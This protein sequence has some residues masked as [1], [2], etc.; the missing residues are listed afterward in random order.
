MVRLS[1]RGISSFPPQIFALTEQKNLTSD[2]KWWEC[3]PLSSIDVSHN[4]LTAIPG[5]IGELADLKVLNLAYNKLTSLPVEISRL[6]LLK[7]IKSAHN[8]ISKLDAAMFAGPMDLAELELAHNQ[9]VSIPA[10]LSRMR[11]LEVLDLSHNRIESLPESL[12]ELAQL[13]TL[14]L[15]SNRLSGLPSSLDR[16]S[17]LSTLEAPCNAIFRTPNLAR[18]RIVFLDMHQNRLAELPA[19]PPTVQQVHLAYNQIASLSG[20]ERASGLSTL[21]VSNNKLRDIPSALVQC[22]QLKLLDVS[23]NDLPTVPGELGRLEALNTLKLDGNPLRAFKRSLISA[24]ISAVKKWLRLRAGDDADR[25]QFVK[26]QKRDDARVLRREANA[27]RSLSLRGRGLAELPKGVL[28]DVELLRSLDLS[29]NRLTRV[30]AE[31]ERHATSLAEL[32]LDENKLEMFPPP[33]SRLRALVS[34]RVRRN[35]LVTFPAMPGFEGL[36]TLDLRANRLPGFPGGVL[37]LAALRTLF[38]G[39]N[40]IREVPYLGALRRLETL[41]LDNNKIVSMANGLRALPMLRTLNLE[42]NDLRQLPLE[43]GLCPALKSLAVSGNPL[44]M[45]KQHTIRQGTDAILKFLRNRIPLE[46]PLRREMETAGRSQADAASSDVNLERLGRFRA[47]IKRLAEALQD[48]GLS[49]A[50]RH[51]LKKQMALKRASLIRLERKAGMR[52]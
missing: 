8:R 28:L 20:I 7:Q 22:S 38:L 31:V 51:A 3:E 43:L 13:K 46:S 50:K 39:S 18:S 49:G 35:V 12:G 33:V 25:K 44:R 11:S 4:E 27:S 34:L 15:G 24:D 5:A 23:N 30:P 37:R 10:E 47:E 40:Q 36:E 26:E 45:L 14:R 9:L 48:L 21:N 52:R 1:G 16:L 19:L 41:T 29:A 42:N 6:E 17:R 2:E 32:N